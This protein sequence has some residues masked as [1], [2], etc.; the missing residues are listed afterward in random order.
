[1]PKTESKFVKASVPS[2]ISLV[3]QADMEHYSDA[4]LLQQT[5]ALIDDGAKLSFS[6]KEQQ[7]SYCVAVTLPAPPSSGADYECCTYWSS[8]LRLCLIDVLTVVLQY[9]AIQHGLERAG[10]QMRFYE[11]TLAVQM[12]G[13]LSGKK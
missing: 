3:A 7:N 5:M 12:K 8:S 13:L 11:Q 9:E 1:M 6:Y 4:E 2:I 10:T